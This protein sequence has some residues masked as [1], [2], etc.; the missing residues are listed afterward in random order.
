MFEVSISSG[1]KDS[2]LCDIDKDENN[3][4]SVNDDAFLEQYENDGNFIS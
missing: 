4:H 3:V 2:S 1:E